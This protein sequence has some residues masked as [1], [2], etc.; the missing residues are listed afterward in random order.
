MA[1][2]IEITLLRVSADSEYLEM[3]VNCP[4]TYL[5]NTLFIT[6]YDVLT[7]EWETTT[8]D[9]SSL[10]TGVNTKV[11]RIAMTAFAV[12]GGSLN[13]SNVTMYKVVF[14][15]APIE[16]SG[17]TESLTMTGICSNVNF[18]YA[19]LL[20]LVLSFTNCCISDLDYDNLD[21][22]HMILYAHT[23]T[24]RLGREIEAK[25]FYDIIWNLFTNCGLST[26]QNNVMNKPCN[27]DS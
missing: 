6:K 22:N 8:H 26:R 13:D 24:M 15:A 21:R 10:I 4:V 19:N 2:M 12:P 14:G 11:M 23:E 17:L 1:D 5:F 9:A 20:D 27:C 16:G 7:H 25:F 3:S 18:V